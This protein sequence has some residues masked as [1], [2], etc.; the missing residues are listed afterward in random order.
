MSTLALTD[1][2]A[3]AV[4]DEI[5][6]ALVAVDTPEDADELWRKVAT[7]EE[8]ARR[9]RLADVTVA[10]YTRLCLR[11]KRRWGELLPTPESGAPKGNRNA[12]ADNVTDGHVES[13]ADRKSVERARKLA[14][15]PEELFAAHLAQEGPDALAEAALTR[16]ATALAKLSETAQ[17]GALD[18]ARRRAEDEHRRLTVSD[19]RAAID[20]WRPTPTPEPEPDP[21]P[22]S[23]PEPP[24]SPPEPEAAQT[25]GNG[26]DASP[27][28]EAPPW[29]AERRHERIQAACRIIVEHVGEID[30]EADP[31]RWARW[32]PQAREAL[33]APARQAQAAISETLAE[34]EMADIAAEADQLDIELRR[35]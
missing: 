1:R 6:Q 13:D 7:V 28:A 35:P 32:F 3:L 29:P 27:D 34:G 20:Q 25:S 24:P 31:E 5:E 4:L 12:A 30:V 19:V 21:E 8:A 15:I 14:A 11:A 16:I 18:E 33:E 9:A 23:D 10:A 22:Q 17:R 26:A 2:A